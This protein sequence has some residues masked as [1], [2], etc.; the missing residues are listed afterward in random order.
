MVGF[1]HNHF[2]FPTKLL[3]S[4][5]GVKC[6]ENPPFK[7]TPIYIYNHNMDAQQLVLFFRCFVFIAKWCTFIFFKCS[8]LF[9]AD[10]HFECIYIYNYIY[11]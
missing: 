8:P 6:G 2:L 5:W 4:T 7:E 3:M 11:M 9:W 10:S 1:P